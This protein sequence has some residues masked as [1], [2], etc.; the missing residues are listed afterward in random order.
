MAGTASAAGLHAARID[1]LRPNFGGTTEQTRTRPKDENHAR[2]R[3]QVQLDKPGRGRIYNSIAETIG[4][5]PLV[6]I[7]ADNRLFEKGCNADILLKLEY[8]QPGWPASRTASA[9]A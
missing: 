3:T 5:T 6:R 1:N 7:A 4:N 9:W 8:L 2:H